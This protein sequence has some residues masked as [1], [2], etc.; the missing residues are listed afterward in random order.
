MGARRDAAGAG[1]AADAD[2]R[3]ALDLPVLIVAGHWAGGQPATSGLA[4][5]SPRWS[6]TSTTPRSPSTRAPGGCGDFEPRTV[7][8]INRP[9]CPVSP[10][11]PTAPCNAR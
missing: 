5:R 3:D 8:L 9:A 11:K 1:L 7:A 4:G 6:T 10:S 2:L